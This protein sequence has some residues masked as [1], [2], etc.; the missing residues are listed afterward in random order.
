[1]SGPWAPAMWTSYL[2]KLYPGHKPDDFAEHRTAIAAALKKPG[3]RKAFTATT[4]T[5]HP[6]GRGA[7]GP[8]QGAHLRGDGRLRPDFDD[9]TG[10]ARWIADRL[11]GEVLIVP[12]AGHYPH[13]QYPDIVNPAL[14]RYCRQ[15]TGQ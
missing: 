9:P 5:S 13:E 1:M 6:A 3:H 4:R 10:E 14:V 7:A 12:E 2:P 15:A 8:G 11:D